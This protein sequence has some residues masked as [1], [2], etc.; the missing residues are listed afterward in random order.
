MLPV[1]QGR[2]LYNA[3]IKKCQMKTVICGCN[4]QLSTF[5]ERSRHVKTQHMGYLGCE[6]CYM[7]FKTEQSINVH[8]SFHG[9]T[10]VCDKCGYTAKERYIMEM[11]DTKKHKDTKQ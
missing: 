3:H 7:S 10:F 9:K 1:R 4:I 8:M 5:N 6:Q 11:H 2:K